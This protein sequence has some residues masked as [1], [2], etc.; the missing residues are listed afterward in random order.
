MGLECGTSFYSVHTWWWPW[1]DPKYLNKIS[2]P[3]KDSWVLLID[4][5][6]LQ[7]PS[8]YKANNLI[9]GK[10]LT[11]K[12]PETMKIILSSKGIR[13]RHLVQ[14]SRL[15]LLKQNGKVGMFRPQTH[16]HSSLRITDTAPD[17]D[18]LK[19]QH[20][21]LLS[22]APNSS[23]VPEKDHCHQ[24]HH[25]HQ[26]MKLNPEVPA[27][28]TPQHNALAF[29]NV[30][31]WITS[32]QKYNIRRWETQQT[33][34]DSKRHNNNRL[35]WQFPWR[36]MSQS[37]AVAGLMCMHLMVV[38]LQHWRVS[39]KTKDCC[40]TGGRE[41]EQRWYLFQTLVVV[42]RTMAVALETLLFDAWHL[43]KES[44][45]GCYKDWHSLFYL[46]QTHPKAY[47][48]GTQRFFS[49]KCSRLFYA[50]EIACWF[51]KF[52]KQ[53]ER[54][55]VLVRLLFLAVHNLLLYAKKSKVPAS[56]GL[57]SRPGV[58]TLPGI[59]K[60]L[61]EELCYWNNFSK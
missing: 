44:F 32:D 47:R 33:L 26:H 28:E 48:R 43:R 30:K 22:Q 12:S 59:G 61:I 42:G 51:P 14:S 55:C 7:N 20:P 39:V 25:H 3:R 52:R 21:H 56:Q 29:G 10:L 2:T 57:F 38:S 46:L 49:T 1:I 13:A 18:L 4:I 23:C 16:N 41:E 34:W 58:S 17:W 27:F 15:R 54:E 35:G 5:F 53:M 31:P 37:V 8:I 45:H 6:G 9:P 19:E 60:L 50:R 11:D 36:S 24:Q 40:N